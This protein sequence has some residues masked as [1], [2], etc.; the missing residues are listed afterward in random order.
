MSPRANAAPDPTTPWSGSALLDQVAQRPSFIPSHVIAKIDNTAL[1]TRLIAIDKTAL[2]AG[3]TINAATGAITTPLG[4]TVTGIAGVTKNL[5]VFANAG[6]FAVS[7]SNLTINTSLIAQP[8]VGVTDSYVVTANNLGGGTTLITIS[9]SHGSVKIDSIVVSA[10]GADV[11]PPTTTAAPSISVAAGNT[12]AS[13]TQTI[14]ETGTG[15]YLV[16][17][18]AAAAPTVAAVKAGTSFAMTAATPVVVSLTGLTASTAYKYYFVAKDTANNDQVAVSAGLAITTT[19]DVTPPATP[20][21]LTLT[22]NAGALAGFTNTT[23]LTLAVAAVTDPS[24]VSW[25]V[26]ESSS[27]P[28]AGDGGW[29]STQPTSFTLS[30]GDGAKSVYV[31][32]KDNV[33]NVQATGKTAAIALDTALPT[34]AARAGWGAGAASGA[35]IAGRSVTFNDTAGG[36]AKTVAVTASSGSIANLV[37]GAFGAATTFDFVAPANNSAAAISVTITY[38][39]TDKSGN[40]SSTTDT[41]SVAAAV[42]A[43][44]TGMLIVWPNMS[45]N[46][47]A[48]AVSYTVENVT[49]GEPNIY[50]GAATSFNA[51]LA[52]VGSGD[53][54][55]I[56]ATNAFGITSAAATYVAP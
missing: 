40:V 23:A 47:V 31:Y 32:V 33:G 55:S 26:S 50:T 1:P 27:A 38:S 5:A 10:G 52:G 6:Q 24:G 29:S 2:P 35:T 34:I 48:G 12:T 43:T 17:A 36:T 7:G 30:A 45:W 41:V 15:Y 13:V 28:A 20:A 8:A 16:L 53:T 39:V 19:A 14:N 3:S 49:T 54:L 11:T 56:T 46:A 37:A 4:V 42:P 51:G 18:A 22:G 44:P 25:F 21:T 9:V